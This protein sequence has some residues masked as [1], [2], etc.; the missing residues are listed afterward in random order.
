MAAKIKL[1]ANM[2]SCLCLN[3]GIWAPAGS[4]HFQE[5]VQ[6]WLPLRL[7][8]QSKASHFQ[9]ASLTHES[10]IG[11][12]VHA[13]PPVFGRRMDLPHTCLCALL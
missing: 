6:V 9:E 1:Q 3:L 5:H 8:R 11:A 4:F 7:L 12:G 2:Q 10:G 13:L